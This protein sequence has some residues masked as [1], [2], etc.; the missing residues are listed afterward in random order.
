MELSRLD[1]RTP[2]YSGLHVCGPCGS[3]AGEV[4]GLGEQRC[5]CSEG[6]RGPKWSGYDFNLVA[7]LCRCCG[8]VPLKS[9]SK[10]SVWFCKDCKEQ[11][12]LL[13]G[14]LNRYVVPIGRHSFHGG[15]MLKCGGDKDA[16]ALD[17]EIFIDRWQ[18][19]TRAMELVDKWAGSVV[20]QVLM[21]KRP[22][23][24]RDPPLL[25]YV[26]RCNP[27]EEE[28]MRRFR[29]MLVFLGGG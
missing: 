29:E 17:A 18:H 9:G 24:R 26:D 22:P 11:V 20:R 23:G 12:G 13:H 5:G 1:L 15:F 10:F 14:R 28:K 25:E 7:E 4:L 8:Q 6:T 27:D 2:L 3:L 21:E 19:I 16:L